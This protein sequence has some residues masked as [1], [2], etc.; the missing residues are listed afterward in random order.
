MAMTEVIAVSGASGQIGGRVARL[1]SDAGLT[2][3]LLGRTPTR[4][5]AIPGA[6]TARADFADPESVAT[7]LAGAH[8]FFLVSATESADRA[9]QQVAV[10]QAARDAGVERIVYLSFVAAA[11]DCTF[12]FGRDHWYTEQ[13]IR[14]SGME[15]TILR[16]N[17]YQDLIPAFADEH[18]VIRGPAGDG[19][20]AAVARADVAA[21]AAAVLTGKGHAGAIH[22]LT[23]PRAFTLTEAAAQMTEILGRPYRYDPETLAQAYASRAKYDAPPWELDG[24][25][26]SYAAIAA[27]DLDTVT[28]AVRRLTGRPPTD[29]ADFLTTLRPT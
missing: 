22:D 23:G 25:V 14:A 19:A 24:W 9:A 10:V 26:T 17:L 7:A 4:I 18:G 29:F 15:F 8:T 13:A 27:G 16:D 1:L 21:A 11:P 2:T 28:D 3:R 20:V 5:P 6:T 12:T